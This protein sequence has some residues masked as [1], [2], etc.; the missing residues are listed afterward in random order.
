VAGGE[1]QQIGGCQFHFQAT[2]SGADM[3]PGQRF[4]AGVQECAQALFLPERADATDQVTGRALR[5]IGGGHLALLA[6]G[7]FGQCLQVQLAGHRHDRHQ[8]FVCLGAGQQGL[9]HL[10][11]IEAELVDSF[12][13]IRFGVGV[14]HVAAHGVGD[15]LA[16]EQVDGRGHVGMVARAGRVA[17]TEATAGEHP[18]VAW[19]YRGDWMRGVRRTD[20]RR[21]PFR[22]LH[23]PVVP[24][25]GRHPAGISSGSGPA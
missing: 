4:G 21:R 1:A 13:A 24:A 19:I 25:A 7:R 11:R 10:G 14:M 15:L 23:A 20:A 12:A 6:A 5:G 22:V 17:L 8:Q 18:R 2:A 9:E 3:Q 16:L